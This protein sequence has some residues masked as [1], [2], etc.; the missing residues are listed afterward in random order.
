M[1]RSSFPRRNARFAAG[2]AYFRGQGR[3][4]IAAIHGLD[5]ALRVVGS[6]VT[7]QKLPQIGK[8]PATSYEGDGYLILRHP[9]TAVVEHALRHLVS[10]VRIEVA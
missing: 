4:R 10:V 3:G 8:E 7:D 2:A 6:L 9:E 1:A 5:P